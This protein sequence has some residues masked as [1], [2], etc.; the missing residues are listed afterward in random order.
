MRRY[1]HL[2][3]FTDRPFEGNQLAVFPEPAGLTAQQMQRIAKEM[4]F[5]E[6]TFI[7]PPEGRRRCQD[8][9]LHA[10]RGAA[11][12]GTSDDRQHVRA[13][14]RRRDRRGRERFVFELGVGPTPVSL[15]WNGPRAGVRVDDA[16]A[17]DVRRRASRIA[18][19]SRRPSESRRPISSTACRSRSSRAACRFCSCR[20]ARARRS[21]PSRS[22]V[23]HCKRVCREA[24]LDELPVFIFTT[25]RAP[26]ALARPCT[27][28]CWRQDSASRR[29]PRPAARAGRSA[30][31][32][33]T[34]AC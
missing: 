10:R 7:F 34:T 28:A 19:R 32:C 3:V 8:A 33:C 11:D 24:G 9:H 14:A 26:A 4:A 29:I 22:I 1:L 21:T 31:T 5:S 13:R 16:A 18:E 30:A 17:A 2:D 27:A 6:T 15:E 20:Y 12:G 23:R 25:D